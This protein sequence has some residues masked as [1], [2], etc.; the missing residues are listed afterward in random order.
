MEI[1]GSIRL[2]PSRPRR[3]LSAIALFAP[4]FIAVL[5]I[6]W[7]IRVYVAPPTVAIPGPMTLASVPTTGRAIEPERTLSPQPVEAPALQEDSYV[8]SAVIPMIATLAVAPFHWGAS[9]VERP[10]SPAP[11][12][13]STVGSAS[14]HLAPQ[15][16]QGGISPVSDPTPV[17]LPRRRPPI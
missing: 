7:F 14:E 12:G 6:A 3:L 17:P 4:V 15:L 1:E 5:G 9:N 8:S 16:Q 2:E 11:I 10:A 13:I